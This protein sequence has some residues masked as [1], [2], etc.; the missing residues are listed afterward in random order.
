[1]F[2][3]NKQYLFVAGSFRRNL[4]FYKR[5][6]CQRYRIACKCRYPLPIWRMEALD[7]VRVLP[8]GGA[9]EKDDHPVVHF[10]CPSRG[11]C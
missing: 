7:E 1:M 4:Q 6:R 8:H 3:P 11:P 10:V 2:L 9:R 5:I